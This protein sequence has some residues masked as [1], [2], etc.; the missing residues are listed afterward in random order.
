METLLVSSFMVQNGGK[1]GSSVRNKE[2]RRNYVYMYLHSWFKTKHF[3]HAQLVIK[4]DGEITCITVHDS[5]CRI[6]NLYHSS[7]YTMSENLLVS[8]HGGKFVIHNDGELTCM[9]VRD[10]ECLLVS[11]FVM[12]ENLIVSQ[13][14]ILD[15]R[16]LTCITVRDTRC[17]RT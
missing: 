13:F 9:I 4:N 17:P 1:I 3:Y 16:E 6:T 15:V 11:K 10:S 2:L 7:W 5:K 12:S 14:V 8:H